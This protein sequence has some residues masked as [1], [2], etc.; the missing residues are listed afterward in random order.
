VGDG[1]AKANEERQKNGKVAEDRLATLFVPSR[2][3]GFPSIL[4]KKLRNFGAS[5]IPPN[6]LESDVPQSM[7][8]QMGCGGFQRIFRKTYWSPTPNL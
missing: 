8:S 1:G 4:L 7:P 2:N 6:L 3:D 5:K